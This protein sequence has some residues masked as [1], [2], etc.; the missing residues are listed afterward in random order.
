VLSR[1]TFL[2]ARLRNPGQNH[3]T[4]AVTLESDMEEA[5]LRMDEN[6]LFFDHISVNPFNRKTCEFRPHG[7]SCLK[8]MRPED[9]EPVL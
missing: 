8:Q 4:G 6:V 7:I 9:F 1:N 5:K 2:S 3:I